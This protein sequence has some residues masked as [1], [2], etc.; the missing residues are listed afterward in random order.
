MFIKTKAIL[1]QTYASHMQDKYAQPLR[2]LEATDIFFQT[3]L[4]TLP[5][6]NP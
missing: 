5:A 1:R 6:E 4:N 2:K 3:A